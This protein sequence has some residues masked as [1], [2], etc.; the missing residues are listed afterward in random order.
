MSGNAIRRILLSAMLL[1]YFLTLAVSYYISRAEYHS[2][3]SE[4]LSA[5]SETR[6]SR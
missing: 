5:V 6:A 1:L 3:E 4:S 2:N